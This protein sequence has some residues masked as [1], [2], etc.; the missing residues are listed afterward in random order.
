MYP[1]R[2]VYHAE[3]FDVS[4]PCVA[5][6]AGC[7]MF[8]GGGWQRKMCTIKMNKTS[9]FSRWWCIFFF[10]VRKCV[11]SRFPLM[12]M[13]SPCPQTDGCQRLPKI[14]LARFLRNC[15]KV[16]VNWAAMYSYQDKA[17]SWNELP[18]RLHT[19]S[20]SSVAAVTGTRCVMFAFDDG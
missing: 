15:G 9:Y 16:V 7:R 4:I 20:L 1:S 12:M 3:I 2:S 17:F 11:C 14:F 6:E 5:L 18:P 10:P 8:R 13:V 19:R